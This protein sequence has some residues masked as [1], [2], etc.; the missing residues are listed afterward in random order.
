ME[1]GKLHVLLVHFP[2]ALGL[3]AILA[4]AI[5]LA[6]KKD[7]FRQAGLYCLILAALAAIPVVVSG[8][9]HRDNKTYLGQS[10][11]IAEKHETLAYCSLAVLIA[12]TSVRGIRKNHLAGAWLGVYAVAAVAILVLIA[13]TGFYGGQLTHGADHLRGLFGR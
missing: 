1:F 3:S 2:I 4:D 13:L 10:H 11:E 12:A 7:F 8:D 9:M 6:L 5:W